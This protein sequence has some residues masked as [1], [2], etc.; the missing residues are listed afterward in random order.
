M[1]DIDTTNNFGVG[2]QG[3]DIVIM[4]P[5]VGRID[6]EKALRLAAYIVLLVGDDAR[7]EEIKK[8]IASA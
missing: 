6:K 4:V 7:F 1:N 5:Q 3:E 8:A 2:V